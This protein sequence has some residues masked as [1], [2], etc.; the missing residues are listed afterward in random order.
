M[1]VRVVIPTFNNAMLTMQCYTSIVA[2]PAWDENR[3]H[4]VFVDNGSDDETLAWIRADSDQPGSRTFV[5]INPDARAYSKSLNMGAAPLGKP[6]FDDYDALLVLNNDTI[7]TAGAIDAMCECLNEQSQVVLAFSPSCV[8]KSG[9]TPPTVK[10][11]PDLATVHQN[12][13]V[14]NAW[15]DRNH[16]LFNGVGFVGDPY[17]KEGGYAF[18]VGAGLWRV[19]GGFDER[20]DLFGGDYDF[21]ARAKRLSKTVKCRKAY[22]DHLEHQTVAWLGLEREVRMARGRFLLQELQHGEPELV[23]VVIPVYNRVEALEAAIDSVL[24]QTMPFYRIYVVDDGSPDWDRVQALAQKRYS[25]LHGKVW[26]FHLPENRGPGGARN[27]GID[28]SQGKYV[29]FLDSDDEWYPDHLEHHLRQHEASHCLMSYS[30]TAFAWRWWDEATRAFQWREDQHPEPQLRDWRH[31]PARLERECYI[32]T[33][34]VMLWGAMVREGGFQFPEVAGHRDPH[35]PAEDWELFK[36]VNKVGG[37]AFVDRETARTHWAKRAHEDGHHSARLNPWADFNSIPDAPD[38]AQASRLEDPALSVVIP[39]F[40][41]PD[42]LQRAVD[43]LPDN[44]EKVVVVDGQDGMNTVQG[45]RGRPDVAIATYAERSGPSRARNVGLALAKAPTVWFLDDDDYAV[46]GAVQ[47]I[48]DALAT[49]PVVVFDLAIPAEGRVCSGAEWYT[50]GLA[51]QKSVL[52][53]AQFDEACGFAE[54]R[55]YAEALGKFTQIE[56]VAKVVAFKMTDGARATPTSRRVPL[57]L[58][59]GAG[60]PRGTVR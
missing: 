29:A 46:P 50:S 20:Y 47:V 25:H 26:F 27:F 38:V 41:R 23:S 4:I 52:R 11:A 54:E 35:A 6:D 56:R 18:M 8:Q 59:R 58:P 49:W 55:A 19:L 40:G 37:I 13:K 33:S 22:I 28:A 42:E 21:L 15:W 12:I 5:L 32:K 57:R 3:W 51:G 14:V 30:R 44:V 60:N 43:S 31:D 7:V 53:K 34:T 10:K 16:G 1:K 45:L 17:V 36:L 39:T 2:D 24:R 9:V 48:E